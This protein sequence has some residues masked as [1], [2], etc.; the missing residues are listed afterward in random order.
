MGYVYRH[1][2]LDNNEVFYVGICS[3]DKK[4]R[5]Y[6]KLGRNSLWKKIVSKCGYRVEFVIENITFDEAKQIEI[7]LI[8]EYGRKDLG[9]GSLSN[10]TNGGD[11]TTGW[12]A[13]K[14]FREAVSKR[15]K[16][17]KNYMYGKTHSD[18]VKSKLSQINKGRKLP[19]SQIENIRNSLI[20]RTHSEETKKK[21]GDKHKGKTISEENKQKLRDRMTG[22]SNPMKGVK[23][24][25][26]RLLSHRLMM[27]AKVVS[28]DTKRKISESKKGEKHPFIGKPCS[29][30]RKENIRKALTGRVFSE[31]WR[32]NMSK[33]KI[34]T[35]LR[36]ENPKAKIV[37]DLENGIFYDC[38]KDACE[39][40]CAN[41]STF[42]GWLK[43]RV[44]TKNR[45]QY[46]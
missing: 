29:E 1:I 19:Q 26:E 16:G 32:K 37:L 42:K 11:G 18:E 21:I 4:N 33:S 24:S 31:E 12:V 41:Y 22:K 35:Q 30:S 40:I 8:K 46:V 17:E 6:S 10:M 5:A 36:G 20:G 27:A 43:G 44:K 39:S 45:F 23:F 3:N 13:S 25:E 2:R 38:A 15:V 9:L 7:D 14:E 34:G 28:E